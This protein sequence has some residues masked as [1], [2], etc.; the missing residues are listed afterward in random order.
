MA[1]PYNNRPIVLY[2]TFLK[3]PCSCTQACKFAESTLCTNILTLGILLSPLPTI[4]CLRFTPQSP[5]LLI[6]VTG[7][8]VDSTNR[9]DA[10]EFA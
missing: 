9:A 3:L 5:A 8:H 4:Y 2:L 7:H 6:W 1:E 10:P